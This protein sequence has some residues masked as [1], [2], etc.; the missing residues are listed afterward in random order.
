LFIN[1][2]AAVAADAAAQKIGLGRAE[3]AV[4]FHPVDPARVIHR[5]AP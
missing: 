5:S 3:D 2:K 1:A 4:A